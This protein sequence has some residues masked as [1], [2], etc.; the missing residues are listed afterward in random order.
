MEEEIK[1]FEDLTREVIEKGMCGKCGGCISFCSAGELNALEMGKIVSF[2][3][4]KK[5]RAEERLSD[6]AGGKDL[7]GKA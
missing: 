5:M 4:R 7:G 1:T 6:L 2:A 3:R